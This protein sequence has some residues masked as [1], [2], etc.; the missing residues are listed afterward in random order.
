MEEFERRILGLD[1]ASPFGSRFGNMKFI[2]VG[3]LSEIHVNITIRS[4]FVTMVIDLM[5]KPLRECT[6]LLD[7][8]INTAI[9]L[10]I[11]YGITIMDS[12]ACEHGRDL[13][14]D[15]IDMDRYMVKPYRIRLILSDYD[16]LLLLRRVGNKVKYDDQIVSC[17]HD[18]RENTLMIYDGA[19]RNYR[20]KLNENHELYESVG[21]V[22]KDMGIE[23]AYHYLH[24]YL[25]KPYMKS[26]QRKLN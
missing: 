2:Q 22:I 3:R 9:E 15:W 17:N 5:G 24:M 21:Q 14:C 25:M 18:E 6:G 20:F 11:H 13:V 12:T 10:H 4:E 19:I 23:E 26:S 7:T 16:K 8:I 1:F